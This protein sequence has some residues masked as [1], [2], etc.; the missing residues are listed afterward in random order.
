MGNWFMGY[1][2]VG[3]R[4][5]KAGHPRI[6]SRGGDMGLEGNGW[7]NLTQLPEVGESSWGTS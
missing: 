6:L 2:V 3:G 4:G 1:K 5:N 7:G